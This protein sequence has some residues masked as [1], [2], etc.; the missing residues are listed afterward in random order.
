MLDAMQ[1]RH[2]EILLPI[3]RAF[4]FG[5][6]MSEVEHLYRQEVNLPDTLSVS[7]SNFVVGPC[8]AA[9]VPCGC[10]VPHKCDWC[11]GCGWLTKHVK[12]IKD[13][14]VE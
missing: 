10:D 1:K 8:E 12:K 5:A 9:T 13:S 14:E 11:C 7:G 4:G 6:T 3:C 2:R